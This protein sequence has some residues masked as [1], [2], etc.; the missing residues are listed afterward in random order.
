MEDG[1]G[2]VAFPDSVPSKRKTVIRVGG[3]TCASCVA[4]VEGALRGLPGVEEAGVNFASERATVVFDPTA[5]SEEDLARAVEEAGYRFLGLAGAVTGGGEAEEAEGRE[6]RD[7]RLKLIFSLAVAGVS[8]VLSMSVMSFPSGWHHPIFYILLIIT[9]PVQFWAGARFYRGAWSA[10]RHRTA[11]MN[12]LVAVGTTAAFLYSLAVTF[13]P[14]FVEGAGVEAAVYYDTSATIIALI[15]LGRYLEARAKGRASEAIRR[16]AGMQARTARVIRD[17]EEADLPIEEVRVGDIVLVRPGEKVPVDGVV[18]EGSSTVDESML[19]GEPVPV[20]KGPGDEVVGATVNGTGSFRF[21]AT[22]VGSDT[23][24]AQII[25]MVEEAQGSKAPIQR[26]ADRVAA[27]FV[28]AVI[29][30]ALVTLVVWLLVGVEPALNL[31]L[32][33]FVAVLVIAC[34]CALGL[35]TPTAIMVGTGRGAELGILIRGGEV[36]EGVGKVDTVVLD[37]TGTLTLGRPE[38]TGMFAVDGDE[39]G[40][41]AVA[42]SLERASEHPLGAAVVR[43]AEERGLYLPEVSGFEA[44]PGMG[45]RARIGS[46]DVLVGNERLM[47]ERGFVLDGADSAAEAM[48]ET[49]STLL[50]LAREGGVAGVIAVADPLKPEAPE[51][52]GRLRDLGVEVAMLTGDNRRAARA[53]AGQAGIE[54]VLAEVLPGDKAAEVRRLQEEGRV[55]AMVGDG[56]NDAPALAQADVGIAL[57]SG[58]DVAMEAADITLVSGDLRKVA[59][60]LRLSRRTLRTIRQNLFWAFFYNVIGIPVAA[61]V[62][63]PVWGKNGLLDPIY[64]A[65]AMAFSSVSV[66]TNSLRLRRFREGLGGPGD[67]RKKGERRMFGKA[68]DPVCGMKVSKKKAAAVSEY[69]GKT[70]YFCNPNCKMAFDREPER[71]L[72]G[73]TR[74]M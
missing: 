9:A 58:T 21:R 6:R 2:A 11:D 31:A 57:G 68:T 10:L 37:K 53:I 1:N 72:Q 48:A 66:V 3:M 43:A 16:L 27:V 64:A 60:A 71:Y 44:L 62:L 29:S 73:G 8:I 19:T 7:L 54:R 25:R 24:L 18:L 52:I 12:T 28:P 49:G 35:A 45:V 55:V 5:V 17:G 39:E 50:F 15:L 33:N 70:Y 14:S 61:G 22:R 40:L 23:V 4:R 34:P 46:E 63:Y 20:E 65:A 67:G 59:T 26:L 74:G 36:L 51:A 32:L 41:L 38:V 42:A 56:I 13:F 47:R 30:I 69:K